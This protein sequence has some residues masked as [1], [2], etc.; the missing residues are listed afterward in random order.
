[1]TQPRNPAT[2]APAWDAEDLRA[3]VDD[4]LVL[5]RRDDAEAIVATLPPAMF[6][7]VARRLRDEG[8]LEL[9]LPR[10]TP[11]Q[12]VTLLDL[13]V[14]RGDRVDIGRARQW[15]LAIG[16]CWV[17]ADRPR[18]AL[19]DLIQAMDPELWTLALFT[20][21]NI[22]TLDLDDDAARDVALDQLAHLRTWETPDGFFIVGAPDDEAGR[23][24]LR[25]LSRVYEDDLAQ[26]R[27]LVMSIIAAL[28]SEIEETLLRFRSG[29]LADLG[30][31]E[32]QDATLLLRPLDYKVAAAAAPRD[33]RWLA[34]DEAGTSMDTFRGSELLRRAM[35]RLPDAEHGL[36]A[37]EFLLLVNEVIAAQ[38][39]PPGDEAVGERA[40]DQTNAT[41][42]LGLELLLQSRPGEPEPERFLA[43]RITAIGLRDVFRVGYGALD[44]LRR[45]AIALHRAMR[46]STTHVGSLLDRPWGQAIAALCRLYPELPLESTA[47]STRPIRSLVDVARA[48]ERIAEAGAL[49]ALTYL[50]KGYGVDPSWIDRVDEPER[51]T[52][53][54]LLRSAI[55]HARLPGARS[56]FAPLTADD[57]AWARENLLA[58]GVLIDAVPRDFSARCDA[59]GLGRYTNALGDVLL[60]RLRIELLGLEVVGDKP[61]LSRT[62]GLV[63][64]QSVSMWMTVEGKN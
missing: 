24:V 47:Q 6:V 17:L 53:G 10:A 29:R 60:A 54:D 40:V 37:R 7:R 22:I 52:L 20:D 27:R 39:L 4:P 21:T 56:T 5:D 2:T 57:L 25:V 36:R 50:P 33:F 14:W 9:L 62:G 31:V 30:F 1:M 55:V 58:G 45:A 64:L 63:T 38:R 35:A 13:D 42:G 28:P 18:G 32:W 46:V 11:D 44:K 48:T 51:L 19:T 16:E 34:G 3:V 26:G 15:L 43:E 23:S 49:A 12:L 59:L 8:R 61:D 41:L